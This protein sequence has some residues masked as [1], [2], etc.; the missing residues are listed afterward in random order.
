M[1]VY[2]DDVRIPAT[3]GRVAGAWPHLYAGPFDDPAELHQ[4][5]AAI[6]LR[7]GWYQD[8]PWPHGHYDVTEPRRRSAIAAGAVP[9]TWRETGQ[10]MAA[11]R[12][13][14]PAGPPAEASASE[15][16]HP[17]ITPES[18]AAGVP[19]GQLPAGGS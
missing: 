18:A 6:G 19:G 3:V 14:G 11:A 8:K 17:L 2:A 13:R 15:R 1:T 16:E 10:I 4:L 9:V 7:R 12:A 5:A